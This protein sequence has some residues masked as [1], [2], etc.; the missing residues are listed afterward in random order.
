[1][2]PALQMAE[3]VYVQRGGVAHA[4]ATK[5]VGPYR[6]VERGEKTFII[7]VGDKREAV[8][9]D[10]LKPHLGTRPLQPAVPPVRGRPRIVKPP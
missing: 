8:S 10:R 9:I 5:Y 6:V 1:V 4:L 2:Q 3:M 7:I